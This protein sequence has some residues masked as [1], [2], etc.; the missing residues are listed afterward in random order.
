MG[1]RECFDMCAWSL[2]NQ[3]A[4][5]GK[6]AVHSGANRVFS[7]PEDASGEFPDVDLGSD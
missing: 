2:W 1:K 4:L 6:K 7:L 5:A 3:W